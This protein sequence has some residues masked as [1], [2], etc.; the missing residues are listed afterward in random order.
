MEFLDKIVLHQ[1]AHHM[2][3]IKYLLILTHFLFIGYTGLLLGSVLISYFFKKRY[4][5]TKDEK[6]YMNIKKF[7]DLATFNKGASF[8]FAIIPIL[9]AMFGYSQLLHLSNINFAFYFIWSA[10][11]LFIALIFIYSFKYSVHLRDIFSLTEKSNVQLDNLKSEIEHYKS[12]TNLLYAKSGL[13]GLLLLLVSVYF[14][15]IASQLAVNLNNWN[16]NRS[17]ITELFSINSLTYFLLFINISFII[18]SIIVL[19]KYFRNNSTEK[20]ET[21]EVKD[22]LKNFSLKLLLSFSAIL[23]LIIILNVFSK[24]VLSFSFD[25]F[26]GTVLFILLILFIISFT[27]LMIKEN[28]LKFIT[29]ILLLFS[30]SLFVFVNNEQ[31][32]FDTS[33][34]SHFAFLSNE[35]DVYEKNLKESA[36]LIKVA[37]NGADIYNGKCI[38]C[39]QFDKKVVGPPY[40]TV[41]PKYEGKKDQLVKFIL[42][43]V[44]VNPEYPSMPNQG[45]K[46]N[47]AKAVADFLLSNYKKN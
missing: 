30:I 19:Y 44:K 6:Y 32:S 3:L 29:T 24:P 38:A 9:S 37:I 33:T 28:H 45:L 35:Y 40:N 8:T 21:E 25:Y 15:S 41:I 23:P 1:S 26:G 36:G 47:E 18:T 4:D 5:K 46:P 31:S 34:K 39:H 2:E 43:P 16:P 20:F 13:Y 22:Y 7:I 12:S 10:L 14:Y 42:N 17:F 11:F 27:Y